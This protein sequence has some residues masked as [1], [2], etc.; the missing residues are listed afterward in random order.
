MLVGARNLRGSLLGASTA[1]IALGI[2]LTTFSGK[3]ISRM[4]SA[5]MPPV[6]SE[7]PRCGVATKMTR[8]TVGLAEKTSARLTSESGGSSA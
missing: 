5:P 6:E 2:A 4:P 7:L 3:R 8:L 1:T